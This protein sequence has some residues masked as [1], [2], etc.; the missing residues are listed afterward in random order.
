MSP[1]GS[2][3][4][5]SGTFAS[6]SAFCRRASRSRASGSNTEAAFGSLLA[7]MGGTDT[8]DLTTFARSLVYPAASGNMAVR[9]ATGWLDAPHARH[10]QQELLV[11]VLPA[12]DRD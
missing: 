7:R 9:V 3:M 10:R 4:H 1:S 8:A 12:V 2:R 11:L 5:T 6:G